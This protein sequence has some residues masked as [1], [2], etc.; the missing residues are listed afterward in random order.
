MSTIVH[1]V[2]GP[3]KHELL[4]QL[5]DIGR[6]RQPFRVCVQQPESTGKNGRSMID[7]YING[8]E[9]EGRSG[10][11][12]NITYGTVSPESYLKQY[13]WLLAALPA[14]HGSVTIQGYYNTRTR[15]GHIQVR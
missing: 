14:V 9:A 8:L 1:I 4:L 7:L 12:W 5:S 10:D 2:D 6:S 3:S 13:G 15:T 11:C